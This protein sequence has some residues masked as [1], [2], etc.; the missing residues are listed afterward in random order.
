MNP[1]DVFPFF[2]IDT[3]LSSEDIRGTALKGGL[4]TTDT[5]ISENRLLFYTTDEGRRNPIKKYLRRCNGLIID[6]ESRKPLNVPP[7]ILN[8]YPTDILVNQY[9]KQNLYHIFNIHEGTLITLYY[10]KNKWNLST[11]RGMDV[12]NVQFLSNKITYITAF[13][14]CINKA[15]FT[16]E[17]FFSSLN[18]EYSYVFGI[19][20]PDVHPYWKTRADEIKD[21]IWLVQMSKINSNSEASDDKNNI[22][23]IM[24]RWSEGG[25]EGK[26][27]T[28][29]EQQE[30][31]FR[32]ESSLTTDVDTS[33][34]PIQSMRRICNDQASCW[35]A[36]NKSLFGI[37]LLSK[38]P[39]ITDRESYIMI[40]TKRFQFLRSNYYSRTL[41]PHSMLESEFDREK[42]IILHTYLN[43]TLLELTLELLPQFESTYIHIA[44]KIKLLQQK[45]I[46]I[47]RNKIT[48][49][50]NLQPSHE[51]PQSRIEQLMAYEAAEEK[52]IAVI[53]GDPINYTAE[54]CVND[55]ITKISNISDDGLLAN[56]IL[57]YIRNPDFMRYLY[58]C[59]F[60]T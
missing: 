51:Q 39:S 59:I 34:T 56:T 40:P 28:I 31:K 41:F 24:R 18:T 29:P 7:P 22:G 43:P 47:Y 53:Q 25:H 46:K 33:Y 45:A 42:W 19:T 4:K 20:H 30:V 57:S 50:Q 44:D 5:R 58:Y 8:N 60:N 52:E 49:S 16:E 26:I 38:N 13:E 55:L 2:D 1:T 37:I 3:L 54:I 11:V 12:G 23:K 48:Q 9:L 21:H 14:F 35:K 32:Y 36:E 6:C 15:G 17:E 10:Y 27:T